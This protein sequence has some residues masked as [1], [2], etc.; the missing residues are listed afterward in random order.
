MSATD[1]GRENNC[2]SEPGQL[3]GDFNCFCEDGSICKEINGEKS[4]CPCQGKSIYG[5]KTEIWR[6]F[7]IGG[8][9]IFGLVLIYL[10]YSW[11]VSRGTEVKTFDT[12]ITGNKTVAESTPGATYLSPQSTK[13]AKILGY[14]WDPVNKDWKPKY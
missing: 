11:W 3:N 13:A 8:G 5:E 1:W 4:N 2:N 10:F 7:A 6:Y 12:F 9:I 14:S